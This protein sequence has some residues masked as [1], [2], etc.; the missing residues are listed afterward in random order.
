MGNKNLG[1]TSMH[2]FEKRY[3][4]EAYEK[5]RIERMTPEEYGKYLAQQ[6]VDKIIKKI[7]H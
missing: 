2:Q 5:K 6:S 1:I 4:P 3:L 7:L